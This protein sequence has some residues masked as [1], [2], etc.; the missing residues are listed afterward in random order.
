MT[1]KEQMCIYVSSPKS[2]SDILDVFLL[3]KKRFWSDCVYTTVISTNYDLKTSDAYV[4]NS[5]NINDSWVERSL[6]ALKNIDYKYVLLLCDDI[7]ISEQIDNNKI[8]EIVDYMERYSIN[9]CRLK[10]LKKGKRIDELPY[11]SFVNQNTP[12][13]INLQRGIFR[14]EY[15]I[16]LLGD[17]HQSAWKIEGNLLEQSMNASAEPFDDVIAC[18]ENIFPVIHGVEKGKWFPSAIK[19]LSKIDIKVTEDREI[20]SRLAEIK[21]NVITRLSDHISPENRRKVKMIAQKVGFKFVNC[22]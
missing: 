18:N 22:D 15:L 20:L 17:G 7:F 19:K 5:G 13:G 12:Y 11:L 6:Q 8:S 14:R 4:I 1:S 2:Y 21:H 16:E 9:Y 10:P 3:C